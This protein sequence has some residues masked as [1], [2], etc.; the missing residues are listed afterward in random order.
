MGM[1]RSSVPVHTGQRLDRQVVVLMPAIRH[2]GN[3]ALLGHPVRGIA[4]R[5]NH[6]VSLGRRAQLRMLTPG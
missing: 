4:S 3:A 5:R 2:R 1:V 6:K